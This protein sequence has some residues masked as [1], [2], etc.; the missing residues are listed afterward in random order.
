MRVK[1]ILVLL[2]L[3]TIIFSVGGAEGKQAD[4]PIGYIS[5]KECTQN[6]IYASGAM[7]GNALCCDDAQRPCLGITFM[8]TGKVGEEDFV[9]MNFIVLG[10]GSDVQYPHKVT[11]KVYTT[12][13]KNNP[14]FLGEGSENFPL[15]DGNQFVMNI[16]ITDPRDGN[17]DLGEIDDIYVEAQVDG[18]DE[19]RRTYYSYSRDLSI[20]KA[21][22]SN[23]I[24]R[25]ELNAKGR[26]T[27]L[28]QVY[29]AYVSKDG[30]KISSEI[31]FMLWFKGSKCQLPEI[32]VD[33]SISS[34]GLKI[35]VYEYG[36]NPSIIES[37]VS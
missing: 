19:I 17:L 13:Q 18:K 30:K 29:G 23:G 16:P 7:S 27:V 6:E 2:L 22:L 24:V 35:V 33:N 8:W 10:D 37:P 5:A 36:L 11:A 1:K 9:E 12:D 25:A 32:S 3:M 31:R 20:G 21:S 4:M 14:I 15:L 26:P 34:E 28:P